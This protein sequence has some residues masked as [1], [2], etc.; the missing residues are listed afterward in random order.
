MAIRV[1]VVDDSPV[2]RQFVCRSLRLAGVGVTEC[3]E[4][5]NGKEAL[6]WLRQHSADVILCDVN[7]PQM[8]G[9]ELI[10]RIKQDP[11]LH[12]IPILVVS[13]DATVP[14]QQRILA[15]GVQGYLL[16]PFS[17]ELLPSELK[18]VLSTA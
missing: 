8:D 15:L 10:E 11:L 3:N 6:D 17:A 16:K 1:L 7:M 2:M 9:E 13:A 4:A 5:G 18:R 12:L 14:R